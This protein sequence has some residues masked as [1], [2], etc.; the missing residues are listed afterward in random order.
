MVSSLINGGLLK[1][2]HFVKQKSRVWLPCQNGIDACLIHVCVEPESVH[3]DRADTERMD[4][5]EGDVHEA[6]G[7]WTEVEM[8]APRDFQ[9]K[10]KVLW[11]YAR[12]VPVDC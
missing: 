5:Q 12:H 10:V 3:E 8:N 4:F 2:K 6:L 9:P 1:I 7:G 11:Q